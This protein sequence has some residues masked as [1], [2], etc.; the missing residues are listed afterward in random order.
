MSEHLCINEDVYRFCKDEA[1]GTLNLLISPQFGALSP[2]FVT[3]FWPVCHRISG[4]PPPP[5]F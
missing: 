3:F 4:T 2:S 1:L 5:T